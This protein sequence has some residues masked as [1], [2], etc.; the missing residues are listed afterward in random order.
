VRGSRRPAAGDPQVL[1]RLADPAA[2][3]ALCGRFSLIV[4]GS[5]P[6]AD[7]VAVL[8]NA[9]SRFRD[10]PRPAQLI[11][12]ALLEKWVYVPRTDHDM[13]Y[14]LA[15]DCITP[16]LERLGGLR[17]VVDAYAD[18]LRHDDEGI[19]RN[20]ARDLM[21][22]VWREGV[23]LIAGSVQSWERWPSARLAI[24]WSWTS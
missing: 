12:P 1:A 7:E 13:D 10:D 15:T 11:R 19:R 18:A 14:T 8:A 21:N 24:T 2:V 17:L 22:I 3:D 23:A 20:A 4:G 6:S 9:L 5:W 16:A